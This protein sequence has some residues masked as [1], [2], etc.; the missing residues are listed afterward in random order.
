MG[1]ARQQCQRYC[2]ANETGDTCHKDGAVAQGRP[3]L[4][5]WKPASRI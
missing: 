5:Y 3:T 2:R 4:M 1:S